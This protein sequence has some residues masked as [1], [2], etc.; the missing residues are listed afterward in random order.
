[1][2]ATLI[3]P[4]DDVSRILRRH[5]RVEVKPRYYSKGIRLDVLVADEHNTH[6]NL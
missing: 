1:M 6:Y 4:P 2:G 5:R 3:K